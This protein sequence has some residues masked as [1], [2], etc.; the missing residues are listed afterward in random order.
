MRRY[1]V[2]AGRNCPLLGFHYE[3]S[4]DRVDDGYNLPTHLKNYALQ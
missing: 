1:W 4:A 2:T 3:L